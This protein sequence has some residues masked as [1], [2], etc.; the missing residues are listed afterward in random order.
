M[1]SKQ[2]DPRHPVSHI[3]HEQEK[4]ASIPTT[5]R[6]GEESAAKG[7]SPRD[8]RAYRQFYPANWNKTCV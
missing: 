7:Y 5:E 4:R 3:K 6:Q 8:L 1:S 2:Y